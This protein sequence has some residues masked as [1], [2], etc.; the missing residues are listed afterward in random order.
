MSR[1]RSFGWMILIL[2]PLFGFGCKTDSNV[3]RPTTSV[4][5]LPVV[6]QQPITKPPVTPPPPPS[7]TATS[8]DILYL[9]QVMRNLLQVRSF[10]AAM[11]IPDPQGTVTGEIEFV[12]QTGL[13]GTLHLPLSITSEVY[14]IEKKIY[15]RTNT[16]TWVDLTATPDGQKAAELFRS[17]FSLS[18]KNT[19]LPV[20]GSAKM[21][22]I[23]ED[24]SPCKLYTFLQNTSENQEQKNEICVR[25]D[26]PIRL[27]T[28][29][30]Q[31][32]VEVT[33]RDY[34]APFELVSPI[35]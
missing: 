8:P 33:Y 30:A 22:S 18:D 27:R 29:T 6:T 25:N 35:K 20:S 16:S 23:T 34:N 17:A 12:R 1:T 5:R 26:L 19:S 13:H 24:P 7:A 31:G 28:F 14:L 4:D 9:Q 21:I 32:V 2:L 10:R 3:K 15:F 11:M